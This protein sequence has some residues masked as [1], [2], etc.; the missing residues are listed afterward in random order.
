[1]GGARAQGETEN[2]VAVGRCRCG[3]P[4]VRSLNFGQGQGG[5]LVQALGIKLPSAWLS[6]ANLPPELK[7][8]TRL[9]PGRPQVMAYCFCKV[10]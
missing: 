7:M 5:A 6:M 3:G 2:G 8:L 4:D 9:K 10:Q 1:M